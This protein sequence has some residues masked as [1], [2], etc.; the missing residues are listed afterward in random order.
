MKIASGRTKVPK[1]KSQ[2]KK[3]LLRPR[4]KTH[5]IVIDEDLG[6][7]FSN[8]KEL[9]HFFDPMIEKITSW[10]A[11]EVGDKEVTLD[12]I[13]DLEERVNLTLEEPDEVWMFEEEHSAR[14]G[15][16]PIF[17]FIKH[18]ED[19]GCYHLVFAHL[20]SQDEPTFI[21]Y[22]LFVSRSSHLEPFKKGRMVYSHN[23]E[24][25]AFGMLDGDLLSEGDELAVGLFSAMLKLRSPQDIPPEKF[26]ELGEECRDL[27]VE[28]ADEIWRDQDPQG[29][30]LVTFI[31]S[32]PD[33]EISDLFYVVVTKMDP[34]TQVHSLLFSF[35]TCD[36]QLVD[37]YRHGENLDAEVTN[38]E[39]AH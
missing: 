8:E 37:R 20:N 24:Q 5:R 30:V 31:R 17:V 12:A 19:I 9:F 7:K 28:S 39:S 18:Q 13:N 25:V 32:F 38:Q 26:Q 29:N 4:A 14:S 11:D 35:P 36:E 3:K 1:R 6:L 27:T 15:R 33:H 16:L 23:F 2:K 22:H 34:V 10:V 21:Y